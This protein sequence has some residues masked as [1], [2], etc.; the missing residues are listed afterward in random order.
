[1]IAPSGSSL[2]AWPSIDRKRL[3]TSVPIKA[4]EWGPIF[5]RV[6]V[7]LVNSPKYQAIESNKVK[8]EIISKVLPAIRQP[9]IAQA[10]KD[11]PAGAIRSRYDKLSKR[12]RAVIEELLKERGTPPQLPQ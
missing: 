9:A 1:M 7:P 8:A 4:P 3:P 10:I 5:E 6:M 2:F 11:D 12:E